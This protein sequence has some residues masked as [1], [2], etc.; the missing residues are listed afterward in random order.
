MILPL[1]L[2]KTSHERRLS[3]LGATPRMK[4]PK[5]RS[6]TLQPI[7]T[8]YLSF[9]QK[10]YEADLLGDWVGEL[11]ARAC[12]RSDV[13][14]VLGP[15]FFSSDL[16]VKLTV[17]SFDNISTVPAPQPSYRAWLQPVRRPVPNLQLSHRH[18]RFQL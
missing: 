14:V 17:P 11:R 9:I 8:C 16:V 1:V 13:D 15:R 10:H 18:P 7:L 5:S 12:L 6:T 2:K 4:S 3:P